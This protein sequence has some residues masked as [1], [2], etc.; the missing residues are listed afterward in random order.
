MNIFT[1]HYSKNVLRGKLFEYF[2]DVTS[3][4]AVDKNK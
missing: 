1:K 3:N 2:G 4:K